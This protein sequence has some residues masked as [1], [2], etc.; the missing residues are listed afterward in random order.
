MTAATS[1]PSEDDE[2]EKVFTVPGFRPWGRGAAQGAV[3]LAEQQRP[4]PDGSPD[5]P[6]FSE[7]LPQFPSRPSGLTESQLV[8]ESLKLDAYLRRWHEAEPP[9]APRTKKAR[10]DYVKRA[11]KLWHRYEDIV[12]EFGE[13]R[14]QRNKIAEGRAAGPGEV[15]FGEVVSGDRILLSVHGEEHPVPCTVIRRTAEGYGVVGLDTTEEYKYENRYEPVRR[16][17]A[18]E[19]EDRR[20]SR[21]QLDNFLEEETLL[22]SWVKRHARR[23]PGHEG[24][25]ARLARIRALIAAHH[26]AQAVQAEQLHGQTT[27]TSLFHQDEERTEDPAVLR[28]PAEI[29]TTATQS[30]QSDTQAPATDPQPIDTEFDGDPGDDSLP[31]EHSDARD[32][33]VTSPPAEAEADFPGELIAGES[34]VRYE[35]ERAQEERDY[36]L[37]GAHGHEYR[38]TEASY[39]RGEWQIAHMPWKDS[40]SNGGYFWWSGEGPRDLGRALDWIR[41]DGESR[42]LATGRWERH[43]HRL[44]DPVPFSTT[45]EQEELEP[46]TVL[47]RRFGRSGLLTEYSWGWEYGCH[48]GLPESTRRTPDHRFYAVMWCATQAGFEA[49]PTERLRIMSVDQEHKEIC[50]VST[51]YVG[52]CKVDTPHRFVVDVLDPN[53]AS[54]GHVVICGKHLMGRLTNDSSDRDAPTVAHHI[55]EGK[56]TWVDWQDR[57]YELSGELLTAALTAGEIAPTPDVRAHLYAEA[58][59]EGDKRAARAARKAAKTAGLRGKQ[60][61]AAGEAVLAERQKKHAEIIAAAEARE[62]AY[63][64]HIRR[65]YRDHKET[66][67]TEPAPVVDP[68]QFATYMHGQMQDASTTLFADDGAQ[69][70]LPEPHPKPT[71]THHTEPQADRPATTPDTQEP[72]LFEVADAAKEPDPEFKRPA[73]ANPEETAPHSAGTKHSAPDTK[74]QRADDAREP[75]ASS[76][77]PAEAVDQDTLADAQHEPRRDN[78]T[79]HREHVT[80]SAPTTDALQARIGPLAADEPPHTATILNAPEGETAQQVAPGNPE[81]HSSDTT[82]DEGPAPSEGP[83]SLA[84][85]QQPADAA[86]ATVRPEPVP[87]PTAPSGTPPTAPS[88]SVNPAD[89]TATPNGAPTAGLP[90]AAPEAPEIAPQAQTP[91]TSTAQHAATALSLHGRVTDALQSNRPPTTPT[92]L[93]ERNGIEI[94]HLVSQQAPEG[95]PDQPGRRWLYLGLTDDI[96]QHP[97]PVAYIS[98]AE[99]AQLKP[100]DFEATV[101]EWA[102]RGEPVLAH[103]GPSGTRIPDLATPST[104]T[105]APSTGP[106]ATS[107]AVRQ[108]SSDSDVTPLP[109]V[110]G[111]R[112]G[113]QVA[114]EKRDS[115]GTDGPRQPLPPAE[116]LSA[117]EVAVPA[118]PAAPASPS[119]ASRNPETDE[120][121]TARPKSVEHTESRLSTDQPT[122]LVDADESNGVEPQEALEATP[123]GDPHPDRPR[124]R[125]KYAARR[126]DAITA[127]FVALEN[128]ADTAPQTEQAGQKPAPAERPTAN[129]TPPPPQELQRARAELAPYTEAINQSPLTPPTVKTTIAALTT[130]IDRTLPKLRRLHDMQARPLMNQALRLLVRTAELLSDLATQLHAP[131]ISRRIEQLTAQLRGNRNA[132][133]RSLPAPRRDRYL[134]DLSHVQRD[135]ESRLATPALPAHERKALQ[136]DWIV[137]RARW[138]THYK[139]HYGEPPEGL[140][141]YDHQR[142]AGAPVT[143]EA[144]TRALGELVQHL[145]QRAD[146]LTKDPDTR[147]QADLFSQV[148]AAYESLPQLRTS[149]EAPARLTGQ[150]DLPQILPAGPAQ[151]DPTR[152]ATPRSQLQTAAQR[153]TDEVAQRSTAASAPAAHAQPSLQQH[154]MPPAAPIPSQGRR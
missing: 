25:L 152:P 154:Q 104:T 40:V 18:S 39:K 72:T 122:D 10:D 105:P 1:L 53:G 68:A 124:P 55:S 9:A 57:A 46:G 45:L 147:A 66:R 129:E 38:L 140:I 77:S 71:P 51:P 8:R 86:T 89:I 60:I 131:V 135:I 76:P 151:S 61:N 137:N 23:A 44:Q 118:P 58:L 97:I 130:Q 31:N 22:T 81:T 132:Q 100:A 142:L 73:D 16:A 148:A 109:T 24:V 87:P 26:R 33:D 95:V 12:D 91:A 80:E 110:R 3:N 126:L 34:L 4:L 143:E 63:S 108:A 19:A 138:H 50:T 114:Q 96:S 28:Q 59:A 150:P 90:P 94:F 103:L 144:R 64:D 85:P 115:G 141:P 67:W 41:R 2:A 113:P 6:R 21:G 102:H 70:M 134:Q 136:E 112:R 117:R 145:R 27:Q 123:E 119:P 29:Q 82:P 11:Y 54:L 107:E 116:A 69:K 36:V 14:A 88:D 101:T 139:S 74:P 127:G 121:G 120:A 98:D 65:K 42:A 30:E 125:V 47:V 15:L 52:K 111:V 7:P 79:P 37:V 146:A 35:G 99:L 92:P 153:L 32:A 84:R 62:K 83:R 20:D 149:P 93:A 43:S 75:V 49:V 48:G 133:P 78:T 106:S 13:R 5:P 17:D 128:A 56:G